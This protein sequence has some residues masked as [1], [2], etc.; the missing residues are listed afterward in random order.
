MS[1]STE[2]VTG[3]APG[4]GAQ[5]V[6]HRIYTNFRHPCLSSSINAM[7]STSAGTPTPQAR[8]VPSGESSHAQPSQG[9]EPT[10]TIEI[11]GVSNR[12]DVFSANNDSWS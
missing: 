9:R 7:Q 5:Y 10:R 11:T 12:F 8:E 2:Q 6:I 1:E 3:R 4:A